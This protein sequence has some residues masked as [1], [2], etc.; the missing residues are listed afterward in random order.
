MLT[1]ARFD[2]TVRA[3]LCF[4]RKL[5]LIKQSRPDIQWYPYDSFANLFQLVKL[6][7]TC[8]VSLSSL[9]DGGPVL[10]LGAG[11]GALSFFLESLGYAVDAVDCSGA[12]MNRME[13]IRALA[14]A[15]C[16]QVDIRDV[17]IDA[18]FQLPR[19]YGLALVLGIL[20]HLKNPYYA[21]EH[22]AGRARYCFLS[23]RVARF[24]PSGALRTESEPLAYLLDRAETNADP[25][26]YWI[27]TPAGLERIVK[28]CGWS[29]MAQSRTGAQH[30][31]PVHSE[32]DERIFLLLRSEALA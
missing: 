15:L 3:G 12:N 24:T 1:R 21:L 25:T 31:D 9:A 26:N 19:R 8:G 22:V 29:V 11:D 17:D 18:H 16:S 14:N 32:A 6:A 13:G 2:R 4:R 28:R 30:S 20:Y 7:R 27:F 5:D 10:D 23:T